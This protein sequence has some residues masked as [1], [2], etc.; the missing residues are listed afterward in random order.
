MR[1]NQVD[2]VSRVVLATFEGF[3]KYHEFKQIAENSLALVQETGYSKILVDTSKIKVIQKESQE[4]INNE[5]FPKAVNAGVTHMA[6][7]IPQD[8]FGKVSVESTNKHMAQRGDIE[9]QYFT[10]EKS[11]R[12]WLRSKT[13][14]A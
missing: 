13:Q 7:L 6:F 12:R 5:W 2:I 10:D 9:I 14:L 11:A 3:L 4:W 1:T 8:Y